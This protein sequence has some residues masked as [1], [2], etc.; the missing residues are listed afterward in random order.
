MLKNSEIDVVVSDPTLR[1]GN[2]AIGHSLKAESV[3]AYCSLAEAAG[4]PVVE[5]GHGNG[6]GASSCLVGLAEESD[7]KLLQAAR[8][9]LKHSKLSVHIIPGFAT[10]SADLRPAL[11]VGVDIFRVATHC[12]EADLSA[13]HINFLRCQEVEVYGVLMMS[14]MATVAGLVTEAKKMVSYGA[15]AIIIMDSSGNYLPHDVT[16][17]VSALTEAIGEKIGFH[18]HNNL[19][20]GVAN[21]LAAVQ[22]G[23]EI[24]D[25]SI[26]GF[27]AGAGNA[28][29]EALVPVFER[30][31]Y[32]TGIDQDRLF[33]IASFAEID[34]ITSR[35]TVSNISIVSGIAGVFSGFAKQVDIAATKY[36]VDPKRIFRELGA[37]RAVAGQESLIYEI[38][39]ALASKEV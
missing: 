24:V 9:S 16:E 10:I 29:L 6:L 21:S 27:G 19:G 30:C 1:D 28:Q 25:G 31:G 32:R 37:R 11:E 3:A 14:H 39:A 4:I 7:E 18:A 15:Q 13:K 35:P 12:T 36:N 26:R 34:F 22:A 33:D 38:A 20:C 8:R 23:A 17:R 5:V 2:H